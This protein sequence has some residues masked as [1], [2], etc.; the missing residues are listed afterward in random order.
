MIE[1]ADNVRIPPNS[2]IQIQ[3]YMCDKYESY[4]YIY[5]IYVYILYYTR[6]MANSEL[7]LQFQL[8]FTSDL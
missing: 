4:I 2:D 7:Q 1:D 3:T 6:P 5:K 8:Q